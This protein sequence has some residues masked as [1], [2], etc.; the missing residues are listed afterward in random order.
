MTKLS[1]QLQ[2]LVEL[3]KLRALCLSVD[4][5]LS[6]KGIVNMTES[7]VR[8]DASIAELASFVKEEQLDL[9]S[10][11]T[12]LLAPFLE[13]LSRKH[14]SHKFRALLDKIASKSG[15]TLNFCRETQSDE[16][17]ALHS[18]T[19]FSSIAQL[20][21]AQMLP[22]AANNGHKYNNKNHNLLIS[23]SKHAKNEANKGSFGIKKSPSKCMFRDEEED[24]IKASNSQSQVSFGLP[25]KHHRIIKQ[26]HQTRALKQLNTNTNHLIMDPRKSS[27]SLSKLLET[28]NEL[29]PK[30]IESEACG[31]Q[32]MTFCSTEESTVKGK[33]VPVPLETVA[34][35]DP[36]S[37]ELVLG[38]TPVSAC[39]SMEEE[40]PFLQLE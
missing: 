20:P 15:F 4:F 1:N 17:Y 13:S 6:E 26:V 21:S 33:T 31:Q 38:K 28:F 27:A 2:Y 18:S 37:Q 11:E 7:E 10:V 22:K 25:K 19:V 29:S 24:Q 40:L 14:K 39:L 16:H 5:K 32:S 3:T 30:R 34:A 12:E 23:L 35:F 36:F 8:F 9:K